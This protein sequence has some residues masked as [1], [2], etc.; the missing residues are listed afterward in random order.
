MTILSTSAW[1]LPCNTDLLARI[2]SHYRQ[3][4][5]FEARFEQQQHHESTSSTAS[6]RI[7]YQQKRGMRW[8]YQKPHRQ[9][10]IT[11]NKTVWL[12]DPLLKS[13]LAQPLAN[14]T[15]GTPLTFLLELANLQETFACISQRRKGKLAFLRL[16]PLKP[17]ALVSEFEVGVLK[18][19]QL[20]VL[21][22]QPTAGGEIHLLKL[23]KMKRRTKF[24]KNYF[25]FTP[26]PEVELITINPSQ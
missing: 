20:R 2:E 8:D 25:T 18:H 1:A 16:K 14:F 6:G 11:D 19:G 13:V 24:P 22:L 17:L 15:G 12:Y 4:S 5:G 23:T 21:R 9:L 10:V 7:W 3:L 26:P